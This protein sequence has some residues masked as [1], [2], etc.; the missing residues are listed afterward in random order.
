MSSSDANGRPVLIA[1]DGSDCAKRAI[2][3]AAALFPSRPALVISVWQDVRAMPTFAWAAPA[4]LTGVQEMLDLVH[5]GA[6][7]LAGEGAGIAEHEGLR[8][9]SE[10]V[11]TTGS[12]ADAIVR[13]A[14]EDDVAAIVLGSRGY[15]GV[16]SALLGSVSTGVVHQAHRPVVVVRREPAEA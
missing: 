9:R 15:G 2:V 3:E 5:E 4:S 11:E 12:I 7:K 16:R 14:D 6:E 8:A 13:R 1:Y 10:A